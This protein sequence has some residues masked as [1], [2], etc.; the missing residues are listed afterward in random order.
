L[1]CKDS[2][3]YGRWDYCG[4]D[5]KGEFSCSDR[6]RRYKNPSNNTPVDVPMTDPMDPVDVP[7]TDPM[8]P[9]DVPMID[10]MDHPMDPVDD[11]FHIP[12]NAKMWRNRC[13]KDAN[14]RV[15]CRDSD[16]HFEYCHRYNGHVSCSDRD[17]SDWWA[18][19]EEENATEAWWG[20]TCKKDSKGRDRC[21]DSDGRW[22]FCGYD[23]KGE[24]TCSDRDRY[25]KKGPRVEED[26][27]EAHSWVKGSLAGKVYI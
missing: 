9:V 15:R 24:W 17:H 13:K 12:N 3:G 20:K 1:R 2:D 19:E 22:E 14:G 25:S 26:L 11:P 4:I 10:P 21:Q 23:W 7:M 8:D 27:L 18:E 16:G 5:Y 6:D